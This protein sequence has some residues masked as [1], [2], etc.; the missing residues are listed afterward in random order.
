VT[1]TIVPPRRDASRSASHPPHPECAIPLEVAKDMSS[2]R[3]SPLPRRD[4]I[5]INQM[6]LVEK[7]LSLRLDRL[8]LRLRLATLSRCPRNGTAASRIGPVLHLR[9]T[10]F[11]QPDLSESS[12][13]KGGAPADGST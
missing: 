2:A 12:G 8:S 10:R 7:P 5:Q 13:I 11:D 4:H 1:L 3:G 6:C 9:N